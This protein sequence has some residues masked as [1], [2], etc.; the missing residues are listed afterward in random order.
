LP[1]CFCRYRFDDEK[2]EL[3][4][5]TQA[6]EDQYGRQIVTMIWASQELV[7]WRC[8]EKHCTHLFSTGGEDEGEEG[9]PR[10]SSVYML[11]YVRK[12][13]WDKV[14]CTVGKNDVPVCAW[15]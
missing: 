10:S 8:R 5:S 11:V 4:S 6:V 14:M 3:A 7:Y 13:D 9:G 12:G 2:V 15:E 1:G